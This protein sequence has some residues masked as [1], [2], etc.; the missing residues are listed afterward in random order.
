MFLPTFPN[1]RTFVNSQPYLRLAEGVVGA[2][3]FN[4][5]SIFDHFLVGSTIRGIDRSNNVVRFATYLNI[6]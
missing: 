6:T 2:G 5:F 4:Q 3:N 1:S